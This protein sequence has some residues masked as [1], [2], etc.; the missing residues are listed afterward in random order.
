MWRKL[1]ITIAAVV[2][3]VALPVL[4]AAIG[5]SQTTQDVYTPPA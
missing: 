1:V 2:A 4:A 5:I 3:A